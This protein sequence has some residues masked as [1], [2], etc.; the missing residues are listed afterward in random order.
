M[1]TP[2][3]TEKFYGKNLL[4]RVIDNV[5]AQHKILTQSD[6]NK[7]GVAAQIQTG[8]DTYRAAAKAMETI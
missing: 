2:E 8:I 3:Y 6:C 1:A 4:G 5:I 7:V